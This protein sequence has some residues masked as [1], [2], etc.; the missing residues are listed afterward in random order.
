MTDHSRNIPDF[1]SSVVP[2]IANQQ[3]K[4]TGENRRSLRFFHS[5]RTFQRTARILLAPTMD[6]LL[7]TSMRQWNMCLG[8]IA[9]PSTRLRQQPCPLHDLTIRVARVSFRIPLPPSPAAQ[10]LLVLASRISR[11]PRSCGLPRISRANPCKINTSIKS[12]YNPSI[13]NTY[14]NA[15]LKVPW[16]QHLQK[17]RGGTPLHEALEVLTALFEGLRACTRSALDAMLLRYAPA[18]GGG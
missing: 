10:P 7:F 8:N 11:R 3:P 9:C 2:A 1:Q 12:A 6:R 5:L 15:R 4:P 14:K 17:N 13:I 16:N 18:K